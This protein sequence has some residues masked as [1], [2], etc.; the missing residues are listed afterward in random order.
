MWLV[1][2]SRQMQ[3]IGGRLETPG[4]DEREKGLHQA[5]FSTRLSLLT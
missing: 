2:V 1:P 4:L 3:L 5:K